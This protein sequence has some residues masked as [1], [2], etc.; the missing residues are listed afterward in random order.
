M[1]INKKD[2]FLN[3]PLYAFLQAALLLFVFI[4]SI[5]LGDLYNGGDQIVYQRAYNGIS[6]LNLSKAYL[7]YTY[8]IYSVE[9]IHFLIIWIASHLGI[10][11][12]IFMAVCNTFLASLI[13]KIFNALKVNLLI[14]SLFILTNFYLY[15]LFFAAERLKFGFI[16][17]LIAILY[18][19][20]FFYKTP[21]FILSILSHLQMIILYSGK[22]FDIFLAELRRLITNFELRWSLFFILPFIFIS[23]LFIQNDLLMKIVAYSDS[24]GLSD[25]LR[26]SLF[27]I[28]ALYYSSSKLKTLVYFV[29][30]FIAVY[31]VGGD[32]VNMIGYIY[33]L[34]SALQYRN[35]F[36]LGV[37]ATTLYFLYINI[38]FVKNIILYGN[39]F[40]S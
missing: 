33:F 6:S 40:H 28:M 12:I 27:L 18:K 34:Y 30:L 10:N 3:I 5:F 9:V 31:F 38:N 39:G 1:I 35:G 19:G 36:N 7:F 20:T 11:K 16:F 23:F 21:L 32:R 4:I 26:I 29:P 8:N 17:F 25:F 22:I 37:L 13:I 15:V 14:T 2:S 24:R